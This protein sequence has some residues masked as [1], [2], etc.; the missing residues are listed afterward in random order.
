LVDVKG[1]E[2]RP[3][4][5]WKVDAS[6]P[7]WSPDGKR[8]AYI[9]KGD[10]VTQVFVRWIDGGQTA[11]LTNLTEAPG[12]LSWSPDGEHLAFSMLAHEKRK[13]YIQLPEKPEG[14]E[15]AKPFKLYD[16]LVY[17]DDGKGYVREG[18]QHLFVLPADGGTPGKSPA[19]RSIIGSA[20]RGPPTVSRSSSPPTAAPT[21]SMNRSTA[22]SIVRRWSTVRSRN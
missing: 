4:T 22:S 1:R 6:S 15:W 16:T 3:L 9:A 8:L 11:R 7:R 10:K 13:P 20:R 18:F 2:Q 12:E 5:D 17:R 14:A 21:G 19:A